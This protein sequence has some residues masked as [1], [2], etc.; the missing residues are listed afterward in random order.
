MLPAS[1]YEAGVTWMSNQTGEH[2]KEK[3]QAASTH[4]DICNVSKQDI[5]KMKSML[6]DEGSVLQ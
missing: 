3:L 1:C 2:K 6:A 4:E 5:G